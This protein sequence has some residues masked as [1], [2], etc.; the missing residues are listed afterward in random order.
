MRGLVRARR[1]DPDAAA[2]LREAHEL[3]SHV[4]EVDRIGELAAA[5]AE[6]AWLD[7]H[8][9]AVA[10]LTEEALALAYARRSE[11]AIAELR[12]WRWQAG[13]RHALGEGAGA[14]ATANPFRLA[15]AGDWARAA[16][17][18]EEIGCPYEAALALAGGDDLEATREAVER[19]Q[20]MGARPAAAL[21]ARRL[22]ERGVRRI[23]RGP[24]PRTRDNP[25][26]LTPRE[27]EVLSC[28]VMGLRNAQI[29]ERL[30]VSEKTVGHH[31]SAVLR[32]LGVSS[33][34]EAS[35]EAIR[36]GLNGPG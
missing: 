32:K 12:F 6:H 24:R 35:A 14:G 9:E 13:G 33:R 2:P 21:I 18:W 28:L 11:W 25:A 36:L 3:V 10:H 22:R 1:G 7:G 30:V 23:P 17:R 5:R 34:G 8:P 15:V 26:G 16:Q 20:R 27:L 29:A 4:G 31:V 19:L